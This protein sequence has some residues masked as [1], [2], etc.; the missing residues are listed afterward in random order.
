MDATNRVPTGSQAQG[1][2]R[3]LQFNSVQ[4]G[5]TV[6]AGLPG[7]HVLWWQ[8][9]VVALLE[10][11]LSPHSLLDP[12]DPPPPA[13]D[14]G[15]VESTQG[16][17]VNIASSSPITTTVSSTLTRAVTTVTQSTPVPGPSVSVRAQ[18]GPC[19]LERLGPCCF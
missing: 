2:P 7:S 15:E 16:D 9:W 11:G 14:Q 17:S 10:E 19:D 4:P 1:A 8:S 3:S 12:P 13:G 6:Q 5:C 18:E